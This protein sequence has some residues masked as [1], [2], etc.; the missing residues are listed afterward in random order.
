MPSCRSL[1]SR[2]EKPNIQ[3]LLFRMFIGIRVGKRKGPND[4]NYLPR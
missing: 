2:D 4:I 3:I 1:I